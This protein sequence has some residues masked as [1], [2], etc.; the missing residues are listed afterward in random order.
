MGNF[1]Y[2][3]L[4]GLVGF[5]ILALAIKALNGVENEI[6]RRVERGEPK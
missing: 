3:I 1:D 4:G 5:S 6:L 2:F